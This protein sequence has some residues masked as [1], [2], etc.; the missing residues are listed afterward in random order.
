MIFMFIH[1]LSISTLS[2]DQSKNIR[3]RRAV[4][5]NQN[6]VFV[7][8]HR[9][10][11]TDTIASALAYAS[12]LRSTHINAEVYRLGE[13]NN[14]TNFVLKAA[15]IAQSDGKYA[16]HRKPCRRNEHRRI[17]TINVSVICHYGDVTIDNVSFR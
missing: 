6:K 3:L 10:P 11:D 2:A 4:T 1:V 12:F 13:L 15:G 7:F 9:N 14:E 8:G 16:L 17:S 5:D